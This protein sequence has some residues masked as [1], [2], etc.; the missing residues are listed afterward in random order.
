MLYCANFRYLRIAELEAGSFFGET[1]IIQGPGFEERHVSNATVRAVE[2][3]E[4]LV[5]T[6]ETYADMILHSPRLA[7]SV[8]NILRE[9]S[10]KRTTRMRWRKALAKVRTLNRLQG[11]SQHHSDLQ[12]PEERVEEEHKE[13]EED[14]PDIPGQTTVPNLNLGN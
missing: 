9:E 10:V 4:V 14:F 13:E 8:G 5:I 7:E 12:I 6:K 3:T 11:P 2:I 1:S